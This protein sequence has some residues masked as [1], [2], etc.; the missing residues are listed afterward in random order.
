MVRPRFPA[1]L[2]VLITVRFY[3]QTGC[4]EEWKRKASTMYDIYIEKWLVAL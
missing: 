4:K 1:V 2:N 3:S